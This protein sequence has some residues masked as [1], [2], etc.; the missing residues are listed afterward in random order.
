VLGSR[1]TYVRAKVGGLG[2][3]PLAADDRL[4]LG[5]ARGAPPAPAI[6]A[7]EERPPSGGGATARV[8]LGPQQDRFGGAGVAAFLA[9]PWRVT[10]QNDRMG[11]RLDGPAV[12]LAG[13]ADI[14]TDPVLPGA[15]QITGSGLP[16]VMMMDAQT[17]GGY[18]KIAT[19]IGPDLRRVAQARA[20]DVLRFAACGQEEAVA[21]LRVERE[22]IVRIAAA[23]AGRRGRRRGA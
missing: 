11:Y 3:R 13:G 2:G 14:L 8:L 4:P 7:P 20:G 12:P 5:R 19:V 10:P 23:V 15:V 16:I 21:A 17:T 6:L 22:L 9:T 18:A 1:A